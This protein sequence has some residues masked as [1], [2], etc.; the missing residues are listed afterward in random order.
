M[1]STHKMLKST[2][3]LFFLIVTCGAFSQSVPFIYPL[4]KNT[5]FKFVKNDS[6][7]HEIGTVTLKVIYHD[8]NRTQIKQTEINEQDT[9]SFIFSHYA[10][11]SGFS[12]SPY[13]FLNAKEVQGFKA[14]KL[15][16]P[17]EQ[18]AFPPIFGVDTLADVSID[19][20]FN[21]EGQKLADYH[22]LFHNRTI[23]NGE[24]LYTPFGRKYCYKAITHK[25][26]AILFREKNYK[27]IDWYCSQGLVKRAVF[28]N[29]KP[30]Y[31]YELKSVD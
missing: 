13:F 1:L 8:K 26:E 14:L 6:L 4:K 19:L 27:Y 16:E 28:L 22:I 23:E 15:H 24:F 5:L 12:L 3:L 30:R 9:L 10:D 21:Y 20:K 29:E 31:T 25:K 18:L 17:T 11:S 7:N 2:A